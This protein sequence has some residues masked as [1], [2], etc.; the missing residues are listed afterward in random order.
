MKKQIILNGVIVGSIES[1]G[2][3][4]ADIL[5]MREYLDQHGLRKEVTRYQA[6]FNAAYSF[7]NTSAYLYERD[8]RRRPR[9]GASVVPFIVNAAFGIELYFKALAQKHGISLTGHRLTKLNKALPAV[10]RSEIQHVIPKCSK[11]RDLPGPPDFDGY[12]QQLDNT[13]VEWRYYFE[14]DRTGRVSVEPTIFV[15]QVLHEAC[16]KQADA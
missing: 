2:N 15:M 8:L 16:R 13:F 10:A 6:T 3:D 9:N 14:K 12:V 4:E 1:S 11:D 7:A 5:A